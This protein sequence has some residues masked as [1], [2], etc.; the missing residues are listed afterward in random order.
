MDL[1]IVYAHFSST[2]LR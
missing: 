1:D 2:M